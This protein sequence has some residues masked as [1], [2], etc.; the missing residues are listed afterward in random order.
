L[1]RRTGRIIR[2]R[3]PPLDGGLPVSLDSA[4]LL[5]GLLSARI[6]SMNLATGALR[7][8]ATRPPHVGAASVTARVDGG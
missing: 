2:R 7:H 4:H 6:T 5:L 3:T 8:V 1:A